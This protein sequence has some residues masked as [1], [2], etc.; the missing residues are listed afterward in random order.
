MPNLETEFRNNHLFSKDEILHSLKLIIEHIKND[1]ED[2][3]SEAMRVK[4][5]DLCK[6][7]QKEIEKCKLPTL[8]ELWWFYEYVFVC[9]GIDLNLCTADNI[10]LDNDGFLSSMN[11]KIEHK[12]ISVKC[13]YLTVEKYAEMQDVS[14]IT[15]R[16]WIRR[17]KLRN[18]KKNGRDWLISSLEDKPTRGY[19]QAQYIVEDHNFNI[20]EFPL[21][22]ISDSIF[23]YQN[24]DEK[25]EF[26]CIFE[27]FGDGFRNEI[28]LNRQ[29]V[30]HLEYAL[31]SSG[32]VKAD[33]NI[34][35]IPNK[36][37]EL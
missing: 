36:Y 16:Q 12:L 14:P 1:D 26:I 9:D 31:I 3:N 25:S 23:I 37:Q 33:N 17:G 4:K 13:D 32:K 19:E 34:Q 8:S 11:V 24:E 10:E 18:A 21:V 15:V 5:I 6:K 35:F 29:E 20:P 30:E 7:F 28:K 2:N 22:S 27:K